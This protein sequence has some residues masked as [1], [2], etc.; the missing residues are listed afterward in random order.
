MIVD[1]LFFI[2]LILLFSLLILFFY[3]QAKRIKELEDNVA[4]LFELFKISNQQKTENTSDPIYDM[5]FLNEK[6]LYSYDAYETKMK[7]K[8]DR[9]KNV[10]EV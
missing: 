6:G 9:P 2:L 5:P 10:V 4:D 8:Y 3:K 7:S 1:I